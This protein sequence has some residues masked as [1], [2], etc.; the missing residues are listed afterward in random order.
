MGRYIL[1]TILAG[2]VG[3]LAAYGLS[4]GAG[5][6]Y[7]GVLHRSQPLVYVSQTY[8]T[9]ASQ[10]ASYFTPAPRVALERPAPPTTGKAIMIDLAAMKLE[11]YEDGDRVGEL[12][13]LAR[14]RDGTPWE[15]PS[16]SYTI[17]TKEPK[18]FSSI[19]K[20]WMPSS[21]QFFGNFF[22][23]GWPEYESGQ[24]V[25]PGY[26]GGCIRLSNDAAARVYQFAEVGTPVYIYNASE[27]ADL[28]T[29]HYEVTAAATVPAKVTAASYLVADLDSGEALLSKNPTQALPI[30]S[31]SKLMTALVSLDAINQYETVTVSKRAVATEGTSGNLKVGEQI[32]A[33]NLLFPLLLESSNDA[34]EALAEHYGRA[35]F[36][37]LMNQRAR[38]I[39]LTDTHF[40]DPSGLSPRNVSSA[41]DLFKLARYL[42]NSKPYIFNVSATLGRSTVN[43]H[44]VNDNDTLDLAY[45]LGGK[46]GFTDEAKQT[47]LSTWSLPFSVTDNRRIAVIEL[48]SQNR[49]TDA[50][51]L[52]AELKKAVVYLPGRSAPAPAP[53]TKAPAPLA[54]TAIA[55]AATV[56]FARAPAAPADPVTTLTFVGDIMLDRG[57]KKSVEKNAAGNY[58]WLFEN[59]QSFADA[60]ILFGNLEGPASDQG[61]NVGSEYSFRM[62]PGTPAVLARA[63]FDVLSVANNHAGDWGVSAFADTVNRVKAAGLL[64]VGGDEDASKAAGVKIIEKNG[65]TFGFI[66]ASD[67]GPTWLAAGSSTPGIM[68]ASDAAWPSV[69][70]TAAA[71]C[72]ILI[73]SYHFGEEYHAE[74]TARQQQLAHLAIDNGARVVVGHHPHV[75]EPV[76]RYKDGIIVYSLGN[77]IFDQYFSP[78]TMEGQVLNL[79]FSGKELTE[80]ATSSVLLDPAFKPSLRD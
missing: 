61:K 37:A 70:R 63:G 42:V 32:E 50:E 74:P 28:A 75:A 16:G 20:V 80:A 17:M 40:D 59:V 41:N 13:V 55:N 8:Q 14:G 31:I 44:W 33:G 76:E 34:A 4:T 57:V 72:D 22:I 11:L 26:S 2:L 52:L 49:K 58:D 68:I 39:G 25:P 29:K 5:V 21:M 35:A 73:V 1:W 38:A 9:A 6:A 60:D 56:L 3:V 65:I 12:P 71:L 51:A 54:P 67:V 79:S 64:P 77:F 27:H 23:H 18:H 7:R 46:N 24:P 30:A 53:V 78:E 48:A 19:G 69:I 15:T 45:F 66:G 47:M 43:H 10:L 36:I 62:D